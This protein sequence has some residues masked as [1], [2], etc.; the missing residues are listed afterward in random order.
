MLSAFE[1][2]LYPVSNRQY[3]RFLAKTGHTTPS[4]IGDLVFGADES[5]VVGVTWDDAIAYAHWAGGRL[6][7][8]LEWEVA[9]HAGNADAAYPWGSDDQSSAQANIDLVCDFTTVRG[10]YPAGR[11][12][13]GIWDMCGNVWEWCADVWQENLL[14][15]LADGASN[16]IGSDQSEMRSLRGGS[17]NS[18][19][20][21]G[22]CSFRG[23]A[24]RGD[25]RADI[26]FRLVYAPSQGV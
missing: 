16:P 26:G 21:T 24:V 1:I 15:G 3:R 10:S 13:W 22:R 19:A 6:P 23:K 17:F 11:N 14:R 4:L 2:D 12:S 18:F 7:T 20:T 8:E 9:A 25:A 5:P